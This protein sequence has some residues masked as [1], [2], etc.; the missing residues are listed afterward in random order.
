M[1]I[2]SVAPPAPMPTPV[3]TSPSAA[4][5]VQAPDAA[6]DAGATPPAA[7]PPLP[8]GQGPRIDQIA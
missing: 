7:R 4:P 8:P 1:N 2:S 3:V 6:D 5:D